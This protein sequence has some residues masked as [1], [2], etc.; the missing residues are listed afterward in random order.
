[1]RLYPFVLTAAL[2]CS[3]AAAPALA[4]DLVNGSFEDGSNPGVGESY[5]AANSS[6]IVGWTVSGGGLGYV[7]D[8]WQAA[9]GSRSLDLSETASTISQTFAT[10]VGGSY[11]I[12]FD[13]SGDPAS[14][15]G[16]KQLMVAVGSVQP[17]LQVYDVTADNSLTNMLWQS[18]FFEFTA[19]SETTT[20]SFSSMGEGVGPALDNVILLGIDS[21]PSPI[22]EPVTW[23]LMGI[24]FG[25]LGTAIRR[26][27][28][29]VAARA[30]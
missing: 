29:R 7:G 24:G 4:V 18:Y 12:L 17:L 20:L 26:S 3:S 13:M 30:A 23:S 14:G 8:Y 5:V 16:S 25:L 6:D 2:V 10:D 9:N 27:G 19:L 11:A 21:M 22:P 1:M 28:V 15:A